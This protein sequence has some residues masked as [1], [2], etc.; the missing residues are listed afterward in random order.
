MASGM[1]WGQKISGT[2]YLSERA[3]LMICRSINVMVMMMNN[4]EIAGVGED[5]NYELT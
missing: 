3:L 4:D 2:S 5:G 1:C